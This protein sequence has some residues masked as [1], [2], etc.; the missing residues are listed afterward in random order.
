MKF[1]SA[2]MRPK[3]AFNHLTRRCSG[4]APASLRGEVNDE[5]SAGG[6][7]QLRWLGPPAELV[8]VRRRGLHKVRDQ[9]SP[10]I[11]PGPVQG[12]EEVRMKRPSWFLILLG[13][14]PCYLA[15]ADVEMFVPQVV[16]G[17]EANSG[18]V[19]KTT[20][21][22]WNLSNSEV[23][24]QIDLFQ[25]SGEP[26]N[27]FHVIV[28]PPAQPGYVSSA[29]FDI[30]ANGSFMASTATEW[31]A[32]VEDIPLLI[33]WAKI[34][35]SAP[36]GLVVTLAALNR[37][38][39]KSYTVASS[40]SLTANTLTAF[41]TFGLID[42]QAATGLALLNPSEAEE[43]KVHV[44]VFDNFGFQRGERTLTLPPHGKIVQFLHEGSFFPELNDKAIRG[45]L[46]VTADGPIAAAAVRVDGTYWSGFQLIVTQP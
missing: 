3:G 12:S 18:L 2:E 1:L 37:D 7:G 24:G 10:E 30:P 39:F 33:G 32:P 11:T 17:R 27:G 15:G 8:A 44:T 20:F 31:Y 28:G 4:A 9:G 21:H 34:T 22:M 5:N 29:N 16:A 26:M 35:S 36:I 25:N 41:S 43:R 13:V 19:L 14:F 42:Y 23:T 6:S 45:P 46:T 38:E 40:T